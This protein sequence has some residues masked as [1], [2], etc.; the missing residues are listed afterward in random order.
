MINCAARRWL[1]AAAS[2]LLT[3][4]GLVWADPPGPVTACQSDTQTGA[5]L[6]LAQAL[7]AGG[8]IRF[9]CP[10]GSV[11]RVT[12]HYVVKD[13]TLIDGGDAVTLDGGGFIP[14]HMLSGSQNIVLRGLRLRGFALP[15]VAPKSIG[16]IRLGSIVSTSGD[17]ELDDVSIE[18]S[19]SPIDVEGDATVRNSAFVG[20]RGMTLSADKGVAH[21]ENC[22]FT[23]NSHALSISAGWVRKCSFN[24]QTTD[25]ALSVRLPTAPVEIRHCTF[26][27]IRG[28]PAVRL[29]QRAGRGSPTITLRAN[30]FRDNDGGPSAGAIAFWDIVKE[31]RDFGFT[32]SEINFFSALPPAAF[33]LSYNRFTNNRGSRGGAIAADLA[34]TIGMVSTG[35]LFTGNTAS[36]DGGA[37]A[38]SGG[39]LR[40][41]HAL[42]KSNRAGGRGA[43]LSVAPDGSAS[44]SNT[45][46]VK[47]AGPN[48]AIAGN[49]V[50]LT[51]VTV[52]DNMA[53]GLLL[54]A[55]AHVG[56]ILLAHNIP[57][58]C[59][60]IPA[61]AF[62]G[63]GLQSD[64]S[65]PGVAVGEAFLDPFYVPGANSPALTAGDASL[66]R[67]PLVGG[68]DLPF[69][70]RQNAANC[71]LGAFERPPLQKFSSK[72]EQRPVHANPNDE[73][74]DYDAYQPPPT[75]ETQS[76][77]PY[78]LTPTPAPKAPRSY[79]PTAT[80]TTKAPRSYKPTPTP[81]T[82]TQAPYQSPP[83]LETQAQLLTSSQQ[84][85]ATATAPTEPTDTPDGPQT[86]PRT[87]TEA[88]TMK[89]IL[90]ALKA[91]EASPI[92]RIRVFITRG[93][94]ADE[95]YIDRINPGRFQMLVNPRQGGPERII[96]DK[97]QWAR[98][99]VSARWFQTPVQES[100]GS[101][102]SMADLFRNGLSRPVETAGPAGSRS[103]EGAITWT[104]GTSCDG[105]VL[106]R[107]DA[108]GLPLLLRFEG[109]CGNE[110]LR[111]REAFSYT[112]P[113]TIT[114]P[115]LL[116]TAISHVNRSDQPNFP[117]PSPAGLNLV[118][119]V[120]TASNFS[121][122]VPT[123][124]F[125][126]DTAR[127]DKQRT[128]YSSKDGRTKLLA[129]ARLKNAR[130][131]LSSVYNDLAKEHTAQE[132]QKLVDYKVLRDK[133]CVVSGNN[134]PG[135]YYVK[136]VL[137]GEMFLYM[138]LEYDQ[139]ESPLSPEQLTAMSQAF[140]GR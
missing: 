59:A 87:A 128:F 7:A 55:E 40:M 139:K 123:N 20:N 10:A 77:P 27:A 53:V 137:R 43:A 42:F 3:G 34:H 107:V 37:I 36:G 106:L 74:S 58:D 104:N 101:F 50:T 6:N 113:V 111:F 46:V 57:A 12:G 90:S 89:T 39:D 54:S 47:N 52:A 11:I 138:C 119:F 45:L 68:V 19:D 112:G 41:G 102:P 62:V 70:A 18:S 49:A 116:A 88:A 130:E 9:N 118:K 30:T 109:V 135:G 125:D 81:T 67:G 16:R 97:M 114:P 69:Q 66:C 35:D 79:K 73:F 5:G 64:G 24:G 29:S 13:S 133:W 1:L 44:I 132:P 25:Y 56:N 72:S 61:G 51:N 60:G 28:G 129:Y 8:V 127:P 131:T 80:P 14:G 120:N 105:K 93:N 134:G 76:Q 122:L 86:S 26:S 99:G 121:I 98:T 100:P 140:D 38:V 2:T 82:R 63:G 22:Q 65:C 32:E 83:T 17:V 103:I 23:G 48:G 84:G 117:S 33:V 91:E 92:E 75:L 136:V 78:Q 31:V 94:F 96:V 110:S 126:F 71:A 108:T 95:Y 21:I 85:R 4:G 15:P 124:V 115:K